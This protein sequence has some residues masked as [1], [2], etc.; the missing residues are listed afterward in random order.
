MKAEHSNEEYGFHM[1]LMG[2]G[3]ALRH[4]L[5]IDTTSYSMQWALRRGPTI[6]LNEETIFGNK[7]I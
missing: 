7:K 1:P 5:W 6:S 4:I 3:F 2:R